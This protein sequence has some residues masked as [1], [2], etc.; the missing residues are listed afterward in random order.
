VTPEEHTELQTRLL[1]KVEQ[2]LRLL[3]ERIGDA[4][5]PASKE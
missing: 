5:R 1:E 4:P 3:V 2:F